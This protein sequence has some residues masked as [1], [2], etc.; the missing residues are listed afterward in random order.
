[1]ITE[2]NCLGYQKIGRVV[3]ESRSEA[4]R[5]AM[6]KAYGT[7]VHPP[8]SCL[9]GSHF[10]IVLHRPNREWTGHKLRCDLCKTV[11]RRAAFRKRNTSRI[12][13]HNNQSQSL[14][15]CFGPL[16]ENTLYR[17]AKHGKLVPGV[18]F[19]SLMTSKGP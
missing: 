5:W 3:A 2:S 9:H 4:P 16:T 6:I 17:H 13:T 11:T 12:D 8:Q 10:P 15:G 18:W 1:M 14:P 19:E 7:W